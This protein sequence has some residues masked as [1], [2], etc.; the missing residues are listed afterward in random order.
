MKE[1]RRK[2]GGREGDMEKGIARREEGAREGRKNGAFLYIHER[3]ACRKQE[4]QE[5]GKV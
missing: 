4:E 3:K 1:G 2:E 5:G